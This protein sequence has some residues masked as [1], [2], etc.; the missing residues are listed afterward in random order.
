MSNSHKIFTSRIDNLFVPRNHKAFT[1]RIDNLFVPRYIQEAIDDP[2]W[3]LA[4]MEEM[5]A[6][7]QSRTWEITNLPKDKKTVGCKWVFIVKCI[8]TVKLKDARSD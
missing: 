5:N 3:K 1:S 2:N 8:L 7:R 4:V 6:L